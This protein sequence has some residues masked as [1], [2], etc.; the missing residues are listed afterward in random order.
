M[1]NAVDVSL[2]A[3]AR[4]AGPKARHKEAE[5]EMMVMNAPSS[6]ACH[7]WGVRYSMFHSL[8]NVGMSGLC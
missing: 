7:S 8:S 4:W 1:G 5:E 3:G 2:L 6:G